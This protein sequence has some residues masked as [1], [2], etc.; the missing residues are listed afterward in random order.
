MGLLKKVGGGIIWIV[1]LILM[2]INRYIG[3]QIVKVKKD[4]LLTKFKEVLEEDNDEHLSRKWLQPASTYLSCF[5]RDLRIRPSMAMLLSSQWFSHIETDRQISRYLHENP[6]VLQIP[7][8]RP[9]FIIGLPRTGTTF[10]FNILAQD[11]NHLAPPLW[12]L[13]GSPVPPPHTSEPAKIKSTQSVMDLFFD[14][15][16]LMKHE[17]HSLMPDECVHT[18]EHTCCGRLGQFMRLGMDDYFEWYNSPDPDFHDTIYRFY[19]KVLQILAVNQ[20]KGSRRYVRKDYGHMARLDSILKVFPDACIIHP[21]RNLKSIL[22][23]LFS[24]SETLLKPAYLN[25]NKY[26]MAFQLLQRLKF[27]TSAFL[28]FR[29]EYDQSLTP[30]SK[31]QFIDINYDELVETPMLLVQKIYVYFDMTLTP[32]ADV[33]MRKYIKENPQHKYGRHT[34]SLQPYGISEKE[35]EDSLKDYIEYFDIH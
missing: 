4:E 10:L 15:E 21:S 27:L 16:A 9:I 5:S 19:K 6:S 7:I 32:E 24:L 33:A 20:G 25:L 3:I 2:F 1:D 29:E 17:A 31:S 23:S 18:L 12:Q 11:P 35:I 34:Y 30:G 26:E 13:F 22:G 28:K 14:G 8:Q